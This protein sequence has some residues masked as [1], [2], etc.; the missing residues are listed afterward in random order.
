MLS[1]TLA[2]MGVAHGEG[3]AEAAFGA[4]NGKAFTS[5]LFSL[6]MLPWLGLGANH[7]QRASFDAPVSLKVSARFCL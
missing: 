2:H 6:V 1:A 4:S 7:G 3:R 5:V